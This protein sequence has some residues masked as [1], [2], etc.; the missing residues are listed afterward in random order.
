MLSLLALAVQAAERR[1]QT[2]EQTVQIVRLTV[3]LQLAVA[4]VELE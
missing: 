3:L 1:T 4:A 2:K